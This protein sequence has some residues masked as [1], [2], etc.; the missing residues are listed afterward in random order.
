MRETATPIKATGDMEVNARSFA[1]SLPAEN[2]SVRTQETYLEA[3]TQFALFLA[4]H[5]MPEKVA[6]I[7]REPV[8]KFVTDL[9]QRFKPATA[10]NRYRGFQRFF[11]WLVDEGEMQRSPMARTPFQARGTAMDTRASLLT[12]RSV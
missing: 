2:A 10:N 6:H 5:G 1:R 3:V 9:L 8:E 11:K 4:E 12:T 7:S